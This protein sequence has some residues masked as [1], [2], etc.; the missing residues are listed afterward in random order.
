MKQQYIITKF[1][2]YPQPTEEMRHI[3]ETI[4]QYHFQSEKNLEGK[5]L[6][7]EII[8]FTSDLTMKLL[9]ADLNQRFPTC[10]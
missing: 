2:Y 1:S 8:V 7:D 10:L 4:N 6:V 3:E 5:T 9:K